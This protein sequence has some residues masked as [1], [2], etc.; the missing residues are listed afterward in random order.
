M[1]LN[2]DSQIKFYVDKL[3]K[4]GDMLLKELS[5]NNNNNDFNMKL[6]QSEDEVLVEF[7]INH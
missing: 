1:S 5:N 2:Q 6:D 4:K 7:L 3:E